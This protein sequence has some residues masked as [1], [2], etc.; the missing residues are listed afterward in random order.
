MLNHHPLTR[1]LV[2]FEA[3]RKRLLKTAPAGPLRESINRLNKVNRI[4]VNGGDEQHFKQCLLKS[5]TTK[6]CMNLTAERLVN[7]KS[8]KQKL[9]SDFLNDDLTVN[10]IAG[11][12]DPQ[13]FYS[14]LTQL[15]FFINKQ[16]GFI[17]HQAYNKSLFEQVEHTENK[18][19]KL[20]LLMT[21]KDAVKCKGFAE[22]HWWYL[23]VDAEF[24]A[25]DN[26]LIM[27]DIVN[28]I[29]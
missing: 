5:I 18:D 28:L 15:G 12:G 20:P 23:P 16:Q 4:I 6:H 14:Y 2:G 13:R 24:S 11:I 22:A 17:D 7:L 1:W 10:A 25:K 3:Q 26:A 21:E 27:A 9:L 29:K 19:K 8:G